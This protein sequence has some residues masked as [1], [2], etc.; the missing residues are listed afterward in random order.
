MF[1]YKAN[2]SSDLYP[3][4]NTKLSKFCEEILRLDSRKQNRRKIILKKK[5]LK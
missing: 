4:D 2:R 3:L 1:S 5:I